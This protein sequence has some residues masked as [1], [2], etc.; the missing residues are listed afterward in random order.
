M[1]CTYCNRKMHNRRQAFDGLMK[2]RDHYIPLCRGGTNAKE[3]IKAACSK[4]NHVKGDMMPETWERFMLENPSWWASRKAHKRQKAATE[5]RPLR[6]D[7]PIPKEFDDPA[8]QEA[9]ESYA[10]KYRHMLRVRD[11]A[12]VHD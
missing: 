9:F 2:T 5:Y 7:E 6:K 8:Q 10:R 4:C 3:N 12:A 11:T 1:N